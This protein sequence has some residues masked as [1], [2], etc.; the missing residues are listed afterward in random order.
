MT[1]TNPDRAAA[2]ATSSSTP[3]G[4]SRGFATEQVRRGYTPGTPQNAVATPI[5]QTTAYEFAS[6]QDAADIFALRKAGN[7]YSRAANP[8]QLVFEER[9]SALEGGTA[10]VAV[11]SG[12]AAVAV[13]LLA[14]AK[15]GEHIVAAQQLYG[16]TV[17]LF[18]ETFAEWGIEV[19]FV[20]QD[21]PQAWRAAIRPTTRA[22]FAESVTNPTAQVLDVQLVADIA[23][24]AGVPLV[25]DNTVA[26]PY[27]QRPGAHGADIVVH[28]A[29]KYLGGHGT[30]MG[31]VVVDIGSFDFGAEPDR[32][33]QLTRPYARIPGVTLWERFG[34]DGQALAVL[35]KTKYVHD[36][37]PSLSPFNS[38]Q[39]L[40]GLETLDL[41]MGRHAASA[42]AVARFLDGHPDVAVVH[43]PGLE[44]NPWADAART[45]LPQGIPAVF[46]FD[47]A[48]TGDAAADLARVHRVVD[49]LS[50][51]KLVA[52]IGD[53]RSLVAH[54][55]SMTHSHLSPAQLA[56]AGI[57][58]RTVRLSIGLEDP[59][60]L[61]ADL[62]QAL[63]R[64]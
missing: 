33:P 6:L 11:A 43:H 17:D 44:G 42:L 59:A 9:V 5:Y 26:T 37:G 40:Q 16:G 31:G 24:A 39:L 22:L 27:L 45:Y 62:D 51:V 34:A 18:Q 3:S 36:L 53:A 41:R 10:A 15:N 49:G 14:L 25:I 30:S 4:A 2:P 28:S 47:V 46:S 1:A 35:I 61:I 56:D 7:L 12:Q 55:A 60:D 63:R 19:D 57:S 58:P 23:H 32:W 52:N 8:T 64:S 48:S 29:T 38:F 21:D 50:L 54:P 13:A 20:D